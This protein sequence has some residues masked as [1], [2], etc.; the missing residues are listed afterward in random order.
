MNKL[1]IIAI[2][3]Y[4]CFNIN[5]KRA[6]LFMPLV[7]STLLSFSLSSFFIT[8]TSFSIIRCV[9]FR[10]FSNPLFLPRPGLSLSHKSVYEGPKESPDQRSLL[11]ALISISYN[12]FAFFQLQYGLVDLLL[13]TYHFRR[14]LIRR[15]LVFKRL[16]F[17]CRLGLMFADESQLSFTHYFYLIV[18]LWGTVVST[19]P[20]S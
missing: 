14:L 3:C 1:Y 18:F 9:S 19:F 4:L 16:L 13:D 17:L 5:N 12:M 7:V 15:I 2:N 8:F 11:H 10:F 20:L 6:L